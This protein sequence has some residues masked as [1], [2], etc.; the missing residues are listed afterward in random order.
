M[1]IFFMLLIAGL[2]FSSAMYALFAHFSLPDPDQSI[3]EK[4]G[5]RHECMEEKTGEKRYLAAIVGK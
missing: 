3:P 2:L 4:T 1:F 5:C